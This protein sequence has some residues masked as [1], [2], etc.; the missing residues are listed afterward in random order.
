MLSLVLLSI[1]PFALRS[2]QESAPPPVAR[3]SVVLVT[4]DTLRRDHLGCYGYPR[5]T[6]PRVDALAA[7][8]V[9]FERAFAPMATTF[10]SHL[11]ML[12]GLYP[13]QHGH[14]SNRGAVREPYVPGAG[15]L[16]LAGALAATGY[17]TAGF[18]SAVVLG[19]RTGI[20]AGFQTFDEGSRTA[21]STMMAALEWLALVPAGEPFF[22]WVHL[23]DTHEPNTPEPR[24]ARLLAPDETLRTWLLG[25]KLDL[26]VLQAKFEGDRG[27][28]T[29]FFGMPARPKSLDETKVPPGLALPEDPSPA[30]GPAPRLVID[31]PALLGLYARYDAC[32]RQIDGEVGRLLDALAARGTLD[33]TAFV[34][35]GDHGQSLGENRFFGHGLNTQVNTQVPLVV[36]FPAAARMAPRRSSALVSLVDLVPTLLARVPIAGLEEYRSQLVGADV[37]APGFARAHVFTSEAT[38]FHRGD[39]KPYACAVLTGRWKY[40]RA[41]GGAGHLYDL[42]G[43]GEGVD[44][45]AANPALAAELEAVLTAELASSILGRAASRVTEPEEIEL[46]EQL[47]GLGYG[48]GDGDDD[49]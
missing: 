45:A 24:P 44:V 41:G 29:R 7:E 17:R 34:F 25:R 19:T 42:E 4:V 10:P 31:E 32:V 11:S 16:S 28:G 14:T 9:V 27:V 48:G 43:A 47:E 12:T 20:G 18:T 15:R 30:G 1:A 3:P 2:P 21:R 36:R 35:T 40:A 33:D 5:P 13:H 8:S 39:R 26:P 6:S 49:E 22:L 37:L 46:L 23:W 38:E